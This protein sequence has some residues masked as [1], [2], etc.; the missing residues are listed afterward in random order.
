[1]SIK[2]AI[3]DVSKMDDILTPK[4]VEKK[5]SWSYSTWRRRREECLVS[6]YKDA[7]VMESQQ[8]CHVKAKRFEEFLDW[9]SEQIYNQL[10]GLV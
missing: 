1:M 10:F 9:K 2:G 4:E 6:P 5:Y 3:K 7:I 8:R